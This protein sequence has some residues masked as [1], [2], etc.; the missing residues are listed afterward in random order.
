M[1][2]ET[3]KVIDLNVKKDERVLDFRD[4]QKQ[5]FKFDISK[6]QEA[7]NQIIQIKKF[8]DAG[9]THFGAISLTQIPGNPDSIK[10]NKALINGNTKFAAAELMATDLR[11]SV[12]LVLAA[13]TT[14]GRSVINR[15]YHLDRGYESLEK[16]LRQ[17]GAKIKRLK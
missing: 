4:F 13:L 17:V 15:I 9:V 14:K 7:Y 16:K 3:T 5:E 6:L 10:G 2:I 12:S 11:A 1:K 8:E